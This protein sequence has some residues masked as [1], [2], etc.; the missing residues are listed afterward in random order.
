MAANRRSGRGEIDLLVRMDG[1]LVAVEVKTRVGVEPMRHLTDQKRDRMRRAARR[2]AAD[3][4]DVVTVMLDRE[5]AAIRWVRG[6]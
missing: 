5:G 2:A 6:Y 4:I 3:R 1:R